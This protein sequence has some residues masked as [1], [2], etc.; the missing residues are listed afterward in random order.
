MRRAA[1][2]SSMDRGAIGRR[3]AQHRSSTVWLA[4]NVGF[5]IWIANDTDDTQSAIWDGVREGLD[6]CT[7]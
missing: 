4:W 1:H 2:A 7:Q 3:P 6:E 5:I